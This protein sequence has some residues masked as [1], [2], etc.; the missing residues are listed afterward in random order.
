M[1]AKQSLFDVH[2]VREVAPLVA[3]SSL[4]STS[5]VGTCNSPTSLLHDVRS[6][7]G[8]AHGTP[9]VKFAP[10]PQINPN[11]KRS[12]APLG[13]SARSRRKRAIQQEGGSLSWSTD[14]DVPEEDMEDPI[15]AF[16]KLV[17]RAGKT[18][19]RRV[20]RG[21]RTENVSYSAEPVLDITSTVHPG[22]EV[23]GEEDKRGRRASWSPSAERRKPGQDKTKRMSTS[24]MHSSQ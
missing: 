22:E 7:L 21:S 17:K 14:P 11:R 15:V 18:L 24:D 5:S 23:V 9:T 4:E 10:L 12:L 20:R 19:W 2:Q 6:S 16:A 13:A 1:S 3:S 8:S